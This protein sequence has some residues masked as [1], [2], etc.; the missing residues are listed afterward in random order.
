MSG[1]SRTWGPFFGTPN[2]QQAWK[3]VVVYIRDTRHFNSYLDKIIKP[4]VNKP[5][6][7]LSRT[8]TLILLDFGWNTVEFKNNPLHV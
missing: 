2:N 1:H 6:G 8:C 4:S 7:L 3:A 5:T